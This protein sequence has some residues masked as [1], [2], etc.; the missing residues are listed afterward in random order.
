M[1]ITFY[2]DIVKLLIHEGLDNKL[3]SLNHYVSDKNL[4]TGDIVILTR[5]SFFHYSRNIKAHNN[6]I[7]IV[8]EIHGPLKYITDDIDPVSYTHL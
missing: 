2:D 6:N 5:E 8:G 7:K 3:L 1:K 4:S